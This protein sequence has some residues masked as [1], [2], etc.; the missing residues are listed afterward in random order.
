[1]EQSLS[2]FLSIFL[3]LSHQEALRDLSEE[4]E[5]LRM[6]VEHELREEVDMSLNSVRQVRRGGGRGRG[7]EWRWGEVG[8][9]MG[10]RRSGL[11]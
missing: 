3:S 5:E 10:W 11:G 8:E 9:V 7:E 6:E 1:M 2:L 4:Q